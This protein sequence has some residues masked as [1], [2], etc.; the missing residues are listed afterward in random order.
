MG[1][2]LQA[3][4]QACFCPHLIKLDIL[5]FTLSLMSLQMRQSGHY[6]IQQH[7]EANSYTNQ[8]DSCPSDK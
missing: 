4:Q 6:H 7:L 2:R 8:L 1:L 5:D 3:A